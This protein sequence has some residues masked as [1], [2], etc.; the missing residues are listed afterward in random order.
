MTETLLVLLITSVSCAIIGCFLVLRKLSMVSD[1][2]SH[3]VLLGIVIAFFITR[4]LSSI[5][6]IFGAA[7]FGVIT[8]LSIE[9][10][11]YG[12]LV[13]KDDAVGIVFPFFFA[14][15]VILISMFARNTH[16]DTDI[17]L[18]GNVIFTSLNRYNFGTFTIAKSLLNMSI[19]LGINISFITIF[20]KELKLTTFDEEFATVS[21]FSSVLLFYSLMTL[22]SMTSV[23]A[24]DAV[25]AILVISLLI[26]PG[27]TAYLLTKDLKITILLSAL[28]A[29]INALIGFHLAIWLDGSIGGMCAF[30]GGI[31]F[32][33]AFLLNKDGLI[34]TTIRK[35]K[36]K[37][38][39]KEELLIVHIGNHRQS[40][41]E[42]D[43]L[44]FKTIA[45]HLNWQDQQFNSISKKLLKKKIIFK[46]NNKNIFDLTEKGIKSFENLRDMY[47]I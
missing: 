44:G 12:G 16:L 35:I 38:Q 23:I 13:K 41:K 25:G 46:D 40:Y 32:L 31:S 19:M 11:S 33:L 14:L 1:A 29:I 3:S 47:G 37:I 39:F 20:F 17:V 18:M 45:K 2:I 28:I 4:D 26:S 27:A 22:S 36:R 5:W 10:L 9:W 30:I 24:F 21:G 6:L 8:V 7:I 34:T 43:E 42:S 15:A